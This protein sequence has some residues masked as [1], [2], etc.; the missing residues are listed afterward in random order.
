MISK[1]VGGIWG[2]TRGWEQHLNDRSIS[3]NAQHRVLLN[4]PVFNIRINERASVTD[5][6]MQAALLCIPEYL[7][8]HPESI[9]AYHEWFQSSP[10]SWAKVGLTVISTDESWSVHWRE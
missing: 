4:N 6:L 9:T 5:T 7:T 10:W 3:H 2:E 1:V 8:S